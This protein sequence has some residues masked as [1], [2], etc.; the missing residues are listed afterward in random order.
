MFLLECL[1]ELLLAG[2]ELRSGLV[3][4]ESIALR[5]EGPPE[6]NGSEARVPTIKGTYCA[7][8]IVLFLVPFFPFVFLE[9]GIQSVEPWDC[10]HELEQLV[11]AVLYYDLIAIS[12]GVRRRADHQNIVR[13]YDRTNIIRLVRSTQYDG[14]ICTALYRYPGS[15]P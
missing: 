9:Q 12:V 11:E 15:T 2:L 4:R 14:V 5:L 10:R 1:R 3:D 13:E 6:S 7:K 8:I